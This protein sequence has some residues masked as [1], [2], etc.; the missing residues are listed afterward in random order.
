VISLFRALI[1]RLRRR[2]TADGARRPRGPL[3]VLGLVLLGLVG[4][5]LVTLATYTGIELTRFERADARRGV[6]VYAGGQPLSPGTSLRTIELATT[7]GRLRY[8]EVSGTPS[9]P[10]QFRR[11][12][13]AWDV[14]SRALDGGG[15]T[16]P[17]RLRLEL[18][19]ERIARL[20][21][22]GHAVPEVRLEPEVLTSA[23]DRPGED[24][25]PVRLA[26]VP[27]VLINAVLAAEDHRFF[28]HG[29]LDAR[30][31]LRAAWAN[32]R[33]GRITQGG[34]TITQQLVKN[35]LLESE[36]T[37][38]RKVREA[39]L[40]LVVEWRYPKERILEAYLNEAYLGQRGALAL[41]GVGAAARA[42]FGKEV[43][44]LSLPE[45]A[46]LAGMLRAPNTYSPVA[47]PQRARQRRDVVLARMLELGQISPAQMD[48][49]RA[50]AVR[51]QV[52]PVSG[53]AAP[54]FADLVR[55]EVEER[56]GDFAESNRGGRIHTTLD[57]T[58][59]RFA[60]RAVARGLER[61]EGSLPRLRRAEATDR[62]QAV[63]IALDPATG[64]IRALVGG[65]DYALSQFNR[66]AHARRQPGSAFKPFVY[67]AALRARGNGPV[68]TAASRIDDTP[69][70]LEVNRQPWTP[71]NYDDV[72]EGRVSVRRAL[73]QSL[74]AATVRI[75]L[76]VGLP[77]VIEAA[78]GL[79]IESPMAPVPSLVLGAFEVTPLEL[80]R[81]FAPFANGGQRLAAA[82]GLGAVYDGG[83]R[84]VDRLAPERAPALS[85][86]EA[87][88]MTSL[89]SG[90]VTSGTGAAARGL[91]GTWALAGK[92]GT[93]N[94]GRD[95]WFVGYTP[96]LVVLVWVGHDTGEPHGLSAAQAALPLWI[97]F[98][99]QALDAYAPPPFEVPAGIV[100]AEVDGANGRL[101]T[102]SC[103]LVIRETFLA[104]SEPAPCDEHGGLT[105][106]VSDWWRRFRDWMRR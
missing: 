13:S 38:E 1:R 46:V 4:L 50:Q 19:G 16:G 32:L 91:A 48:A 94:D 56:F 6:I 68:F 75:A 24:Y 3:A 45:A 14:Y 22:E 7:L 43:H 5:G 9:A 52:V 18:R 96:S 99:R 83:G 76:E 93:T 82:S 53:Q 31:L 106:Q 79:G 26:E 11:T 86:A 49:A 104:G 97:D 65:R 27:L 71:R 39:W 89:L 44:Q 2:G 12:G 35:R 102:R 41:R 59:Q 92:T 55:Q 69:L 23:G 47:S 80:A 95:A 20:L 42:Y 62:L 37:L 77:A 8:A 70:T 40:A 98:M 72:Y 64:A 61:L 34:S 25:R 17:A 90:V 103:P 33:A 15:P 74:N 10:G 54:Y 105:D 51:V 84:L 87:Y 88:L 67:A 60:E 28:D 66:A 58:L 85:P 36:R 21:R 101:A 29:G 81:A 57:L 78:R 73:E 100:F 63:L 30:G